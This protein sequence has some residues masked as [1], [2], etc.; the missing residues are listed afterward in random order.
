MAL[1]GHISQFDNFFKQ[2]KNLSFV[3]EYLQ[4]AL[5][6][7][8][9][10]NTRI[11][12]LEIGSNERVE[13]EFDLGGS[14]RAIEQTYTL[15]SVQEAFFETH[16]KYVDFQLCVAGVEE[17]LIGFSENF[18][19]LQDYNEKKDLVIYH[20]PTIPPHALYFTAGTLGIFFQQDVHAGG[21]NSKN[22]KYLQWQENARTPLKKTVL[23]VPMEYFL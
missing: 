17:F 22:V 10:E 23:K 16:R 9:T 15:K 8:S 1:V 13:C 2:Y 5:C 4:N 21:L 7:G 20:N 6:V 18:A 3:Q 14:V 11:M 19:I 12:G